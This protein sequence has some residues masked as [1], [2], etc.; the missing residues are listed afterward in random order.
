MRIVALVLVALKLAG[1]GNFSWFLPLGIFFL[2]GIINLITNR[3]DSKE[4]GS[5]WHDGMLD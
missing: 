1:V 2:S 3:R 4:L 5:D